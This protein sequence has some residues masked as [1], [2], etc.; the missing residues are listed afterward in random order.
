MLHRCLKL[1]VPLMIAVVFALP[2]TQP[3]AHARQADRPLILASTS[4]LADVA[5]NVA[6]NNADVETLFPRGTNAHSAEPSAQDIAR[7]G[8]ADLVLVIGVGYEATL[9]PLL[10]EAAPGRVLNVSACVPVREVMTGFEDHDHEGEEHELEDHAIESSPTRW[11]AGEMGD[12]CASYYDRLSWDYGLATDDLMAGTL[13]PLFAADCAALHCDPHVW[14]DP[15][16][17]ALW[18]MTI[19]NVLLNLHPG[20][21]G[22]AYASNASAYL[23][24]LTGLDRDIRAVIDGLPPDSRYVV[25]N[26]ATL[27]YFAARY[28]LTLVGMVIPAGS[29][30]AEPSAEDAVNLMITIQEYGVP[31]I[32]TDN[33]ASDDLAQQIADET[34]A[35]IVPLYTESLGEPGSAADTY[36]TYMMA[37]ATL[38]AHGL[39]CCA[40]E[41]Q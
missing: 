11:I 14:T 16:N 13:G 1:T 22:R 21:H 28:G 12:I 9:L 41:S 4:I 15:A 25:T 17:V 19:E 31:A 39:G 20:P 37:N 32:F 36:L 5:A 24:Q 30:A 40:A 34:G 6:G 7:L 29:T 23:E 3:A 2:G 26:H 27:G 38:I 35:D 33:V 8:Q 18:T 10:E